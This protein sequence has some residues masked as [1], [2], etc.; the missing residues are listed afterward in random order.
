MVTRTAY[1]NDKGE[2]AVICEKCGGT[3]VVG[4]SR[5]P[6]TSRPIKA[7]CS[8]G[9]VFM[10]KFEKRGHYR[11]QV[12]LYGEYVGTGPERETGQLNVEDISATGLQFRT[13]RSNTLKAG[14]ILKVTFM[15]DDA[16]KS[17]IS[18]LVE[19]KRVNDR[20]VGA[21]YCDP[22]IEKALAFY[23]MP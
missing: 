11:K 19:V 1:I 14:D 2:A 20:M 10:V 7:R 5:I 12:S 23:L 22:T 15:L 16:G 18:K 4:V 21:Q 9:F 8:C 6:D 13:Q 3:K 17:M